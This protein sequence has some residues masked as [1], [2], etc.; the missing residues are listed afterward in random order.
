VKITLRTIVRLGGHLPRGT[1][2]G[3]AGNQ[4]ELDVTSDATPWDVMRRLGLSR[5]RNYLVKVNGAIVPQ[6]RHGLV[7]LEENDE[8]TILPKP[9]YG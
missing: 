6:P 3:S 7:R 1:S 4:I 2:P 8:V 9:K 5:D